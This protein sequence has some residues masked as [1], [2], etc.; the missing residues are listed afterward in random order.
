MV[1]YSG[2]QLEVKVGTSLDSVTGSSAGIGLLDAI[3]RVTWEY[4]NNLER[5]EATGQRTSYAIVEGQIGVSGTIERFWTGSGTEA[6]T[7]GT[8]ETGSLSTYYIGI[9]PNGAVAGQPYIAISE[10]KF[11]KRETNHRPG[12]NLMTD[13]IS[14]EGIRMYTG[15]L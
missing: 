8:N 13:V 7:R 3:Q 4:D 14:F 11:G 1:T 10:V 9:Y 2:W 5:K 15:S 6:W 12:S